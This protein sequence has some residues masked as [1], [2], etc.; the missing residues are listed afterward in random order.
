MPEKD[1]AAELNRLEMKHRDRQDAWRAAGPMLPNGILGIARQL[2]E[3]NARLRQANEGLTGPHGMEP[4][5]CPTFHDGCHCTVENLVHNIE[6]A[7][8]AE[9]LLEAVRLG[10]VEAMEKSLKVVPSNARAVHGHYIKTVLALIPESW[11]TLT[12]RR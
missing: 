8:A 1:L 12:F 2:L 9:A 7:E 3:E 6:R 5:L 10:L 11:A 4:E